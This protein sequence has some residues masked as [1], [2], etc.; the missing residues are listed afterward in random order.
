MRPSETFALIWRDIDLQAGT[1]SIIKSRNMGATAATKTVNS[2][3]IIQIDQSLI[4]ILKL[5]PSRE[6]G[7]EHVFVGKTGNPMSKKWAEHNWTAP[8]KKLQIRHRSSTL[9]ATPRLPNW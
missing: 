7:I 3:R 6:V 1:V 4:D 8:L 5:L 2:E 9:A